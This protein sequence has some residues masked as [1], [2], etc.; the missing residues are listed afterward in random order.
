MSFLSNVLCCVMAL[1]FL[2]Q[3]V[4][5]DISVPP[6]AFDISFRPVVMPT[7]PGLVNL[8]LNVRRINH[9]YKDSTLSVEIETFD[10]L[11]YVG[12][13]P[14]TPEFD[15]N[16]SF[17]IV[18]PV[19]IGPETANGIK[20][21]VRQ[22]WYQRASLFF[23]TYGDS[24]QFF[25]GFLQ[26]RFRGRPEVYSDRILGGWIRGQFPDLDTVFGPIWDSISA[27]REAY[28]DSMIIAT[29]AGE[30]R[31]DWDI[32][33]LTMTETEWQ[34]HQML[35]KEDSALSGRALE[36][37]RVGDTMFYRLEGQKEFRRLA[38][39]F[40]FVLKVIETDSGRIAD[41]DQVLTGFTRLQSAE[42]LGLARDICDSLFPTVR[43][44]VYFV[45]IE[46]RNLGK[47]F[48]A[49]LTLDSEGL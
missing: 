46:R 40:S 15:N 21:T 43:N 24:V 17:G 33:Y 23:K 1:W 38:A 19:Q 6:P 32:A 42:Q 45:F 2:A 39:G 22:G 3:S 44:S 13:N 11:S 47:F 27:A 36:S 9:G 5:A 31:P 48:E 18:I 20:V 26:E 49:G 7:Q 34:R 41:P 10:G 30:P 29:G 12:A 25:N 8:E 35:R 14:L 28:R 37:Y 4:P 16:D